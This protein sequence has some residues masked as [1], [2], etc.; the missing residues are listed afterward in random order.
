LDITT[1]SEPH[2]PTGR[3]GRSPAVRAAT[4]RAL[5]ARDR[6]LSDY[7]L[8]EAWR[9]QARTSKTE[10]V[11]RLDEL[12]D[13]LETAVTAWGGRVLRAR[14]ADQARRLI[15]NVAREHE[16]KTVVKAKSMTTE[17]IGLNPALAAAGLQTIETDLGEF[18]VQ[19][20]GHP[21][22]HITAPALHLNRRQIAAIFAAHPGLRSPA[23]PEVLSRQA[24]AYLKP[25]FFEAQMG[26]T[27]VNFAT[28]EGILILLENESNL[29]FTATL[30]KVHLALMGLEK[31]I[32]RLADLEVMLR[33]LPASATGQ[34]LTA[35]VHFI[36]GLKVQPRGDQAFYLVILDN[37]RRRLAADPEL[38]EALC[39]LRCGACLNI[40]PIFQV[41]AAHLYGRVYPGAIGILLAPYL[42]P[43]GDICDL[44][45]QCGACQEICPVGIRLVDKIRYLRGHSRRFRQLRGIS[46]AAG[47]VLSQP[48]GYRGLEPAL[49]GLAGLASRYGW[50]VPGLSALSPESFHRR[51]RS[52]RPETLSG[53]E[54]QENP[55]LTPFQ[56]SGFCPADGGKVGPVAQ[57][58]N[59]GL[60][61]STS[62]LA[63]RLQEAGS[64]LAEVRGPT[65]LA[66]RLAAA[67]GPLWL[68]DHPWLRQ[69]AGEL[70][71]LGIQHQITQTDWAPEAGTAVTV[72]L[73]AIPE[74]GSV[75]V[76]ADG[77]PAAVL[78]FRSQNQIVLIPR[79][80]DR[81]S[82][83]QALEYVQRRGPGLVSW[84]TG[85][86]RTADIE[87]VLVL[88]AQGPANLEMFL[89]R[90]E[91]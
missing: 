3:L 49:R 8:W 57:D 79:D 47:A 29:R 7:P 62:L 39:C 73:G 65:A 74:T 87:K 52:H 42:A 63:Q 21:P 58:D 22:A 51:Q 64:S 72:A 9:R 89:Y 24:A 37:G 45:T 14:D 28:P 54:F 67:P 59:L 86:S 40:C 41:G 46:A 36:R 34:R 17:E 18:I 88:G 35:L 61:A 76:D 70:D 55:P 75:L 10:A 77:G 30:P 60:D 31:M 38:A 19:L 48:R 85:P 78:P 66:R 23:E 83:S 13:D 90:E 81:L 33:L 71:Q 91:A 69:V 44:C 25:H 32:P 2:L 50:G 26:I 27:G 16:V 4:H 80:R 12:L 11:A 56:E 84:L 5:A 43:V 15:L 82:L 20:A 6:L 1:H 68:Q 53:E